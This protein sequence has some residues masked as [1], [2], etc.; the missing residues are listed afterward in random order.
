MCSGE[1]AWE[2]GAKAPSKCEKV[3]RGPEVTVMGRV[4]YHCL[5]VN[6]KGGLSV[7]FSLIQLP[8]AQAVKEVENWIYQGYSFS[9]Q[10]QK[11]AGCGQL[12]G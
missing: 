5:V 4:H 9:K 6:L 10:V 12:S 8:E 1:E 11:R 3:L 2:P 7:F